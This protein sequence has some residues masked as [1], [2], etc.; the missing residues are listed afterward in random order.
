[1]NNK[2]SIL[3][4]DRR[5]MFAAA[6]FD[7][8]GLL[9]DSER[10]LMSAWL[11]ASLKYGI[12]LTEQDYL[13]TVGRNA[14][15]SHERLTQLLGGEINYRAV[16][17]VVFDMLGPESE[18]VFPLKPGAI[19]VLNLLLE[20][21]VPCTLASSTHSREIRRRLAAVDVLHHFSAVAGSD[22]VTRGKPDPAV[23]E[24]AARRI[25]VEP[26]SCLVFED[27]ENGAT[28][29]LRAGMTVVIIPDI[30]APQIEGALA[31]LPS[32]SAAVPY[33][34]DWFL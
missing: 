14:L 28:A 30:R 11:C 9:L 25:D 6:I 19:V 21:R 23:Y 24:L 26:S 27:S 22:E 2:I 8:D 34:R 7:M 1:M 5:A 32:L 15:E 33:L 16:Q 13:Y 17:R 20:M 29:A 18:R 3:P 4:I 31:M 10:C 12:P